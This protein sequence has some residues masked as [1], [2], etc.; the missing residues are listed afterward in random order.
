MHIPRG[1]FA[2]KRKEQPVS[3]RLTPGSIAEMNLPKIPKS[4]LPPVRSR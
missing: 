2:S 1:F 4:S 3:E